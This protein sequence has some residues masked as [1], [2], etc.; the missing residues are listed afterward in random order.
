MK[1]TV[2]RSA[3]SR[4][5]VFK[6]ASALVTMVFLA[7]CTSGGQAASTNGAGGIAGLDGVSAFAGGASPGGA[8]TSGGVAGRGGVAASGGIPSNGGTLGG[9]TG[10]GGTGGAGGAG[11]SA[12]ASGGASSGG[13]AGAGGMPVPASGPVVTTTTGKV[14]GYVD[15]KTNRFLGIPYAAPP[16][17][18]LRFAPPKPAAA[19]SDVRTTTA[20]GPICPQAKAKYGLYSPNPP[21]QSED[22]L[23][24]NVYAPAPL[25]T[26]APVV[27]FLHGGGYQLGMSGDYDGAPLSEAGGVVFVSM[28]YRLGALGFLVNQGLDT[29]LGVPSG[30]MGFRDQ[31]LALA[32]VHDNIAA[33]G[34]DPDNVTLLGTSCL[35]A[36]AT[37][38]R[39]LASRFVMSSNSCVSNPV[40]DL[41]R[42][43]VRWTSDKLVKA[44]C[45]DATDVVACLRSLPPDMLA[46]FKNIDTTD[47]GPDPLAES[48]LPQM[49]GA[50]IQDY[51]KHLLQTGDFNHGPILTGSNLHE[52]LITRLDPDQTKQLKNSKIALGF[53]GIFTYLTQWTTISPLYTPATDAD[54]LDSFER[55]STDTWF[56]C[57][58]RA[59]TRAAADVGSKVYLYSFELAP[60][61]AGQDFDYVLGVPL[62]APLLKAPPMPSA[63]PDP[64]D[65]TLLKTMQTYWV[66]FAT[67]GDPNRAAPSIQWP[68]YTKAADQ[69]LVLDSTVKVGTAFSQQE[70]DAWDQA[71]AMAV[72]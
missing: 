27:V 61:A 55:L 7:A 4:A 26:K 24:L 15:G 10:V 34:G 69:H 29:A 32:W 18:A 40:L 56:R 47:P 53:Y 33:F 57:P 23:S 52:A 62:T 19:W 30:N 25:G 3:R 70:C 14:Q 38:S 16:T 43:S 72:Y 21:P 37:G 1:L 65:P 2:A 12:G 54:S 59:L 41:N 46:T 5:A 58:V 36:F 45:P 51:P 17:G 28:N 66:N 50:V 49:D 35:H 6:A 71:N 22:C 42:D 44:L 63:A 11:G 20:L 39:K 60:A 64:L 9:S 48:F 8:V 13:G 31:Q 68:A 67:T